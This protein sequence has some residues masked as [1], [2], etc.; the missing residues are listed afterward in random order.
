MDLRRYDLNLLV[1][2]EVL[3]DEGSVTAAARRLNL[4]QSAV[5]AALD[6]LR[7]VFSDPLLVR[8]GNAMKPTPFARRLQGPLKTALASVSLALALPQRFDPAKARLNV[9][10][11]ITDYIG[12]LLLPVLYARLAREAPGITLE[13]LPRPI[14]ESVSRASKDTLAF[15]SSWALRNTNSIRPRVTRSLSRRG[16]LFTFCQFT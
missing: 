3:L 12:L 4:S 5:S 10:L 1:V 11:G 13:V 15:A 14:E 16:E 2:L 6:R 7:G 9:R 8:V